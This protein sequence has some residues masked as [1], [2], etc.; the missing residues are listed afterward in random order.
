MRV[1]QAIIDLILQ[2][3]HDERILYNDATGEFFY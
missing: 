3:K 1:K 2:A